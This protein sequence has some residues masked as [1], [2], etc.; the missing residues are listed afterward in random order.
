ML[1]QRLRHKIDIEQRT[2]S[3]SAAGEIT[4]TWATFA[5]GVRAGVEPISGREKLAGG[6]NMGTQAVRIVT[7]YRPGITEQMR[8][9]WGGVLY[10]IQSVI[11]VGEL[12]RMIEIMA[13]RGANRG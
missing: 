4:Q 6:A 3:L 8:I 12:D 13:E 9:N 10:D 5:A 7:R 1:S 2:Q 11:T